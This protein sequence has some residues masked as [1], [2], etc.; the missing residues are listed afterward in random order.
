MSW[1]SVPRW[2]L[3]AAILT[4]MCATGML[5][6]PTAPTRPAVIL[7]PFGG[8]GTTAMV[9]RALG[10]HGVH[11][12]LSLDYLRLARWRIEQSGHATKTVNRTNR[13]RQGSLLMGAAS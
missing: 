8:T 13:D 5:G 9:A 3:L 1:L 4:G 12:D 11:L 6:V 10:R 7:D 2:W